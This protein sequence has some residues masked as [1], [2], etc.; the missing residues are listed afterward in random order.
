MKKISFV[1]CLVM[2]ILLLESCVGVPTVAP[3]F[4][5]KTNSH[6]I[7]AILPYEM[8]FT[9]KKP[10]K[11]TLEQ[12]QKIEEVESISFQ[13]SLYDQLIQESD[14][15]HHP[16]RVDIQPVYTTNRILDE[17]HIG[18]R[19]SWYMDPVELAGL[20][21]VD[22]VVRTQVEKKRYMSNGASL[23][24]EIGSAILSALLDD[25]STFS[26]TMPTS[27]IKIS[28]FL[29]NGNDGTNLWS[30]KIADETDWRMP[31]NAIIENINHYISEKFPYR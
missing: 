28:C 3:A 17:N 11:L 10:K 21:H 23:G 16:I 4:Y 9:G 29:L 12:V 5:E 25:S 27:G 26:I 20:L 22:A 6:Q 8:I 19:D 30:V 2:L 15:S 1:L 7:I 31:A 24:I 13:K 18:I 14:Y